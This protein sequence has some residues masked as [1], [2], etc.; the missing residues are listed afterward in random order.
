MIKTVGKN[1][2]QV[3]LEQRRKMKNKGLSFI[4]RHKINISTLYKFLLFIYDNTRIEKLNIRNY[5]RYRIKKNAF[6][7][8]NVQG[9]IDFITHLL[10]NKLNYLS[11]K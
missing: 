10:L 4:F 1:V 7:V 5:V 8:R 11:Y 3:S 9:H 6:K 2:Y